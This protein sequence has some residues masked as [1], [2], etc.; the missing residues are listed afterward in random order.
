V[1]TSTAPPPVAPAVS[2]E[3]QS[4]GPQWRPCE[5]SLTEVLGRERVCK[6]SLVFSED[7]DGSSLADLG[8]WTAEVR[9]PGEP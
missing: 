8:N 4:P 2:E 7:F 1:D 9:F 3:D 5:R 6:G